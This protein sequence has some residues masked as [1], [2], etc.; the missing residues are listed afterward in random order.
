MRP[1]VIFW[2]MLF[3]GVLGYAAWVG[4][5][6]LS[7]QAGRLRQERRQRRSV[8]EIKGKQGR[9]RFSSERPEKDRCWRRR[10]PDKE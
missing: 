4:V 5:L 6:W 3:T 10:I 1:F 7:N 2:G 9:I 8:V